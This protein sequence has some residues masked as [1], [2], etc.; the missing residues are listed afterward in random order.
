MF[1]GS[2][3]KAAPAWSIYGGTVGVVGKGG[4]GWLTPAMAVAT[5]AAFPVLEWVH[6]S[7]EKRSRNCVEAAWCATLWT[8]ILQMLLL[9]LSTS[10]LPSATLAKVEIT[11]TTCCHSWSVSN[12]SNGAAGWTVLEGYG[13][14]SKG[15]F[16]P[17]EQSAVPKTNSWVTCG[18]KGSLWQWDLQQQ[19]PPSHYGFL[20]GEKLPSMYL[21]FLLPGTF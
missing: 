21:N 5:F 9:W 17:K 3:W 8:G 18:L 10:L 16:K 20:P 4:K 19:W 7:W 1:L 14:V 15:W 6:G 11:G 2:L 12:D 13:N